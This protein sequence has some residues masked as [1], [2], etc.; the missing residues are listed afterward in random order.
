MTQL[1][2]TYTGEY[3]LS[4]IGPDNKVKTTISKKNQLFPAFYKR[5]VFSA[6]ANSY[7]RYYINTATL[8]LESPENTA[9]FESPDWYRKIYY[10]E[11]GIATKLIGVAGNSEINVTTNHLTNPGRLE[12]SIGVA[13]DTETRIMGIILTSNVDGDIKERVFSC[14]K[15]DSVVVANASDLIK[16]SYVVSATEF[17]E[18]T[19]A[20]TTFNDLGAITLSISKLNTKLLKS[21]AIDR[22]GRSY[23]SKFITNIGSK[24]FNNNNAYQVYFHTVYPVISTTPLPHTEINKCSEFNVYSNGGDISVTEFTSNFTLNF[25]PEDVG[26]VLSVVDL[27]LTIPFAPWTDADMRHIISGTGENNVKFDR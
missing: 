12:C 14:V 9:L 16:I 13:V 25:G 27:K 5:Y 11:D 20:T 17:D 4:I 23:N 26:K 22:Y 10:D 3:H 15:F 18:P 1:V 24:V 21:F 2:S 6:N 19:I 8:I 7:N